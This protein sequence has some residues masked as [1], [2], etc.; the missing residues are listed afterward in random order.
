LFRRLALAAHPDRGGTH[1]A[2]VEVNNARERM[3]AILR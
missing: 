3:E 2:M 1:A